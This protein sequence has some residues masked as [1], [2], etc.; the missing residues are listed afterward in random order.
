MLIGT[1]SDRMSFAPIMIGASVIPLLAVV[2][3]LAL[4]RNTPESHA[5]IVRTI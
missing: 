1:I 4:V 3:V 2:A 5:G